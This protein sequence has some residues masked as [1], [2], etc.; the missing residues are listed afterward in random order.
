MCDSCKKKD[1]K[2]FELSLRLGAK[3]RQ[4]EQLEEE[5]ERKKVQI[6]TFTKIKVNDKVIFTPFFEHEA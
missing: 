3:K 1:K 5:L 4:V 2:I 6:Y